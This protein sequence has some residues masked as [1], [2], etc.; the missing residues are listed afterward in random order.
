MI[1]PI[2]PKVSRLMLLMMEEC[3]PTSKNTTATVTIMDSSAGATNTYIIL[4]ITPQ[5]HIILPAPPK[6]KKTW[7]TPKGKKAR[8]W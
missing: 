4:P 7:P 5:P 2:I 6:P 1:I 8:S 3:P